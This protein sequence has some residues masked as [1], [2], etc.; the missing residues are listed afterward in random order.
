MRVTSGALVRAC[1]PR[2][3][4]KNVL[5]LAAP[6]AAGILTHPDVAGKAMVAFVCFCMLSSST[7]LLN[8]VHDRA[9]D[10][11]DPTR[12]NR[13][14]AAGA[15]SM[16]TA[17]AA[18]LVLALGGLA[19]A[20]AVHPAL[21]AVGAGYLA[22]TA[23]Y[24]LWLRSVAVA[25]IAAVAGGFV[26]RA[27]AGGAATSV[28]LSRWF[29]LVT[30]FGA[31][32]VVTGK[33]YAELRRLAPTDRGVNGAPSELGAWAPTD[34]GREPAVR[35]SNGSSVPAVRASLSAYSE[36]YLRFVLGLAATV[37]TTGYCLWAFQRAHSAKLS[38]YELTVIPFVLWLLR[39]ALLLDGGEGRAPE[40]LVLRD[41]FLMTMSAAWLT[42]F[43][44]GVYVAG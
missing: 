14:I 2:Q 43:V 6:A 38:W 37:T 20:A 34:G 28:P 3:W 7:Y 44:T 32:F 40:E 11:H 29:M 15:L 27:L 35:A 33:R 8:D 23:S 42:V 17:V 19:L 31:L 30:S 25:D 18:A 9:E 5:V 16:R 22:L 13:P 1:R 24:T 12:R 26:L 10:R 21:A 36:R 39:Y 4:L 41:R